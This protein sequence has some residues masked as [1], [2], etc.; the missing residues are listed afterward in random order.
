M[1]STRTLAMAPVEATVRRKESTVAG[2]T[3]PVSAAVDH[4]NLTRFQP[5]LK[6]EAS[7]WA[8]WATEVQKFA[9]RSF[10][11]IAVRLVRA[12]IA[13]KYTQTKTSAISSWSVRLTADMAVFC[14]P[15]P[16]ESRSNL[17]E[18]EPETLV[19]VSAERLD[20]PLTA[21][22]VPLAVR[23]FKIGRASCRER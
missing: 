20:A 5:I 22:Q 17:M 14:I 23:E 19:M 1:L 4:G 8:V 11:H 10:P 3:V 2:A 12:E 16:E 9:V 18:A 15:P 7:N 13:G 21:D 6:A